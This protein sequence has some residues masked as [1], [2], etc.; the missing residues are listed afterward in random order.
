M[1]VHHITHPIT[2][3]TH[4]PT[5]VSLEIG[6]SGNCC[7]HRYRA[8][9][10][11]QSFAFGKIFQYPHGCFAAQTPN[12][13]FDRDKNSVGKATCRLCNTRNE[14]DVVSPC[15]HKR[16]LSMSRSASLPISSAG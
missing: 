9:G 8:C 2:V 7:N 15:T 4:L 11:P 5:A 6:I 12:L 16:A 10:F 1:Q 13:L 14:R 3:S